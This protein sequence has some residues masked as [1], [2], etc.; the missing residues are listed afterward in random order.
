MNRARTN[1]YA[2]IAVSSSLLLVGCLERELKPLNPC[3]VSSVAATIAG[4][5][6][7]QGRPACSWSTTRTRWPR[8]RPRCA[9]SSVRMIKVLTTGDREPTAST[10]SRPRRTCTSA[11]S[12]ATWASSAS[13]TST[14]C[15]NFGDDGILLNTPSRDVPNC[16]SDIPS[17]CRSRRGKDDPI[18]TAD[19][20]ACIATLGTD[21]CGFEQQLEAPLKALWPAIDPMPRTA[22][23]GSR[24][25]ATSTASARRA[26]ATGENA[27]FLRT[28]ADGRCRCSRSSWS[29]T[30]RTAR[31]GDTQTLQPVT[32]IRQSAGD[33]GP[34]PALLLQP[35]APLPARALRQGLQGAAPG[36][37]E[38]RDLRRHRRRAAGARRARG[39]R[40][41]ELGRQGA[42]RRV[43]RGHPG[44][45]CHAGAGR[46]RAY[47]RRR[48]RSLVPSCR[49]GASK[50]YPPRRIVEVARGFGA[51]G[52]VHSICQNDFGP[53]IDAI[54]EV[55]ARQLGAVCLPRPL[56]R[57][58]DGMVG[59]NVVW[60]LPP[61]ERARRRA[62]RSHA[63]RSRSCAAR[64][65]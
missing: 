22:R 2:L 49:N 46:H 4:R 13:A 42:A 52:T 25:P 34:Q 6:H 47:R 33:A 36:A 32:P 37:R 30:R 18:R 19:D 59:C 20:F 26:T 45:P 65:A 62:R 24:S 39:L 10:T 60:E 14:S 50:A 16:R 57:N 29:P 1:P 17:S 8:S 53:A 21:G 28:G 61:S 48:R 41:R 15:M 23:I 58:K 51:N 31:A 55:I 56:V 7:R 44:P 3:L 38:S 12:R 40:A 27:G 63:M 43:L 64:G 9:S 54:I 35:G 5:Q 11:S